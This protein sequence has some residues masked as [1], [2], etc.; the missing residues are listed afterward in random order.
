MNLASFSLVDCAQTLLGQRLE[1]VPNRH[2][3]SWAGLNSSEKDTQWVMMDIIVPHSYL[4][5]PPPPPPPPPAQGHLLLL[6]PGQGTFRAA[7]CH[8]APHPD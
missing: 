4:P 5:P 3:A 6:A 7:S 1:V 8:E 2:L